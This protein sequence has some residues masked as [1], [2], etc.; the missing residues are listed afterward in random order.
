MSAFEFTLVKTLGGF[1]LP[2]G[3]NFAL[4]LAA[5]ALLPFARRLA[6]TMLWVAAGSLYVLS[7]GVAAGALARS[8]P[9]YPALSPEAD[10]S[11]A[12]AIAVVAG[13]GR[14]LD[15]EGVETT[16]ASTLAR[17]RQGAYLHR[18][19]GLPL[20]VAGGTPAPDISAPEAE[21]MVRSLENDFGV[22][23]RFVESRSLNT[24]ENAAYSAEL[25]AEAG[26]T[27]IVL[28]THASHMSRAMEEFRKQGIEVAPSPLLSGGAADGR[29]RLGDFLPRARNLM[30]STR[31]LHEHVGRVW[32]RIRY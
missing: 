28:V 32:Y 23:P 10:L 29:I 21:L 25:L 5:L 11:S 27:H 1:V 2:P 3:A 30:L 7:T 9:E 14:L 24:A 8:L 26:I 6:V 17:L 18:R 16:G 19:T 20:L 31:S 13:G 12:G 4:A 15:L 22:S